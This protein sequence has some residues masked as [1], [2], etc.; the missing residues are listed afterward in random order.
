LKSHLSFIYLIVQ[1]IAAS[2]LL[3]NVLAVNG[4]PDCTPT[5]LS[6][7]ELKQCGNKGFKMN[8]SGLALKEVPYEFPPASKFPGQPLCVMDLSNNDLVRVRSNAFNSSSINASEIQF[9]NLQSNKISNMEE[10]AF[11]GLHN[12][13]YL[14]LHTNGLAWPEHNE[15]FSSLST[16]TS[17]KTIDLK[18][19]TFYTFKGLDTVLLTLPKLN[20]LL[21]TPTFSNA[22]YSFGS[23]F[24]N[25]SLT[26]LSV[27]QSWC[28]CY[29]PIIDNETFSNL[30]DLTHLDFA[31]CHVQN[32]TPDALQSLNSTL[33][34]LDM[35]GNVNLTFKGMNFALQGLEN[36]TALQNLY[37][38]Y[39]H[40]R[41]EQS[42]QLTKKDMR[43]ISTMTNLTNL[44]M[45]RNKIDVLDPEVMSM[46]PSTVRSI[47]FN[48]NRFNDGEYIF[49]LGLAENVTYV[50]IS[51][52]YLGFDPFQ[53][54]GGFNYSY[55]DFSFQTDLME[56]SASRE[57]DR[58]HFVW[59]Y[60]INEYK[61]LE[62][63]NVSF[64]AFD[65]VELLNKMPG[66]R[67]KCTC[68]KKNKLHLPC[69]PKQLKT[70]IFSKSRNYGTIKP[71]L[72]CD[73]LKLE[74]IDLSLNVFT[75][76]EGPVIGPENLINL[77]LR[78][79][80]C[81]YISKHF[82]LALYNLEYLDI[83]HN[84]FRDVFANSNSNAPWIFSNQR[85]L[86]TLNMQQC[87]IHEFHPSVFKS[88]S[89]LEELHLDNN[90]LKSF[91]MNLTSAC[92]HTLILRG[93]KLANLTNELMDYLDKMNTSECVININKS[94]VL[95]L[96]YNPLECSCKQLDFWKWLYN[97]N[98]LVRLEKED[99][100]MSN[101]VAMPVATPAE[102]YNLIDKLENVCKDR[103]WIT[104]AAAGGSLLVG[105]IITGIVGSIVYRHRWKIRYLIYSR[106]LR[107]RH[108]GF[109]RL[110]QNDVM[111]S[112]AKGKSKFV[113]DEL[114]PRLVEHFDTDRI[115]IFDRDANLL[116]PI[117]DNIIAG[118][119]SSRKIVL[120]IDEEYV[121][122]SW[123]NYD[124]NMAIMESIESDR[125]MIIVVLMDV[126]RNALP[127]SVLRQ[128]A[129]EDPIVFPERPDD[130]PAFWATLLAEIQR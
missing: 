107:Y 17:L 58:K 53:L 37:V 73:A 76:W 88:M 78:G 9:L 125:N 90:Y 71:T 54:E 34:E 15:S 32:I 105:T 11:V 98:V 77:N 100:C 99:N 106:R 122:D 80:F 96:S 67:V 8:C 44:Y 115:W 22:R 91:D 110:F 112:Y 31:G 114:F 26:K 45:N 66:F 97:T 56:Y 55:E 83:S 6:D 123:C 27:S 85:K 69:L 95:D 18:C 13:K 33:E 28:E 5:K 111:I 126:Q 24:K 118:I 30:S 16:L 79:N 89:V 60:V 38:N 52:Q 92:F 113:K 23:G 127:K 57:N 42:V 10:D 4:Y 1:A 104:W 12:L 62:N 47:S 63:R 39:L 94:V 68:D 87:E 101:G 102:V 7:E 84:I 51:M 43:Y 103:T 81:T 70:L 59:D 21:I 119:L 50:D 65:W 64:K 117:A 20:E 116:K 2:A 36:S 35:S 82:F 74:T 3:V 46:I 129:T 19:N 109:E 124:L 41:Y 93:N 75:K 29:L 14:N 40:I 128:L 49:H 130:Q 25:M 61:K 108:Q 72:L 48:A 121:R 86:K 120:F